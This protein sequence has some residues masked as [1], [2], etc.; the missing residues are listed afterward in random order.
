M[1]KKT[2]LD[3]PDN[4]GPLSMLRSL[5]ERGRG[6]GP[7][8]MAIREHLNNPR[9]NSNGILIGATFMDPRGDKF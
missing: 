8:A 5:E 4:F 3:I 6:E 7:L 2:S 9:Q 1:T